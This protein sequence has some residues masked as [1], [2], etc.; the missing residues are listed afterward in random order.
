MHPSDTDSAR[1]KYR[2][3]QLR[4]IAAAEPIGS[5]HFFVHVG[6]IAFAAVGA[7]V[8]F[9]FWGMA[10]IGVVYIAIITLEKIVAAHAARAGNASAYY[11]V[12][13]LLAARAI[14][15]N[16]LALTVWTTD[17]DIFKMAALALLLAA[18]INIF[19]FHATY[20]VVIS[21]V[22]G[23]IWLG[24][25]AMAVLFYREFGLSN[26][27]IAA[28]GIFFAISPYFYLS[29]LKANENWEE[30]DKT[31]VALTHSQKHDALG[32]LVAGVAHDFNNITAITLGAAEILKDAPPE[33]REELVNEIIKAAERGA[34]LSA[35]LLAFGRSS[36]LEP[37]EHDIKD[38]F[39]GLRPILDRVLPESISTILSVQP[40]TPNVFADRNQLETAILN[41]V[42]NARDAMPDGG[43]LGL[44]ASRL[45]LD[46]NDMGLERGEKQPRY[47]ACLSV[48]DTGTGIPK[49]IRDEVFDPFFTTKPVGEGSGLGLSMVSGFARQSGGAVRLKSIE[50]KGTTVRLILPTAPPHQDVL[51]VAEPTTVQNNC[52]RILLVEDEA[53]LRQILALQLK[54]HGYDVITASHGDDA[55]SILT[56]G[57]IPDLLITDIVMPGSVQG[58]HL[59]RIARRLITD[60]PI[61]FMSGYPNH[62]ASERDDLQPPGAMLRKP[63]RQD[64]LI[65][66]IESALGTPQR[67]NAAHS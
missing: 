23:P 38:I 42:I 65:S 9:G 61:I 35:Q 20:P 59:A 19:V 57:L 34:S 22:V 6:L 4:S 36:A 64:K 62:A 51:P 11:L 67:A 1:D 16:A 44:H 28:T 15:Y 7:I 40:E 8:L 43:T 66:S 30:L 52:A 26:E 63:I 3:I 25:A 60:I 39:D 55:E 41:L 12:L 24:F 2:L 17:G 5:L 21:C 45:N 13:T 46:N 10:T 37:A 56:T 53:P 29:L 31:R 14:V 27:A 49:A 18:T 32:K 48:T 58:H 33:E 54:A 47:S 50:D